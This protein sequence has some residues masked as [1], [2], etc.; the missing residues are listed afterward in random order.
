MILGVGIDIVDARRIGRSIDR[1]SDKFTGRIFTKA[2][3]AAAAAT[4]QPQAYL[5]K[6]F[7]AKEAVYKALSGAGVSGLRWQQAET[8]SLPNGTPV[9]AL[10]G[11]CKTA[12]EALTPDGY[13]AQISISLSDEPPYALAFVIISAA[14]VKLDS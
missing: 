11:Q 1:F 3:R 10:N 13:K 14:M 4:C 7:A 2:E 12:L 6:R 5:A 9:M 8:L